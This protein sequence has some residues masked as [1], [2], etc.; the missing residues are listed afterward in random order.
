VTTVPS[1]IAVLTDGVPELKNFETFGG[2]IEKIEILEVE[3]KI[4][5][6]FVQCG[7]Q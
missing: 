7:E 5:A 2:S 4:A 6:N 3:L 1:I